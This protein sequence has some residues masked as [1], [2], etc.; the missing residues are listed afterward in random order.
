MAKL[1]DQ[2]Q[3][4]AGVQEFE[5]HLRQVRARDW[6]VDCQLAQ[7]QNDPPPP[8]RREGGRK[9]VARN[10]KGAAPAKGKAQPAGLSMETLQSRRLILAL[11]ALVLV[12]FAG[13]MSLALTDED[14][15]PAEAEAS[16]G[17]V[18]SDAPSTA[19]PT[20]QA[21]QTKTPPAVSA[22]AS[23]TSETYVA[24]IR[25]D[26]SLAPD[27]TPHTTVATPPAA[28]AAPSPDAISGIIKSGEQS[29]PAPSAP[30]EADAPSEIPRPRN[31]RRNGPPRAP[32]ISPASIRP[33]PMAT[34]PRP[35]PI[36]PTPAPRGGREARRQAHR[37]ARRLQAARGFGRRRQ[38]DRRR[39]AA[40]A[41]RR[42]RRWD[43][44]RGQAGRRLAHW[45]RQETCRSGVTPKNRS[46]LRHGG[47]KKIVVLATL[48]LPRPQPGRPT[49][50]R[51]SSIK[52]TRSFV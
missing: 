2:Q 49:A 5:E 46:F 32:P 28:V 37:Q 15:P 23:A 29:E 34:Q 47:G 4:S 17:A 38:K 44:R 51:S 10:A 50:P 27:T 14:A 11:A 31:R 22:P 39:A 7:P 20:S 6:T 35:P 21:T 43:I 1:F 8:P 36:P 48:E 30:A 9:A 52:E 24:T 16:V 33:P 41:R 12:T 19:P 42:R 25:P 3:L 40:H 18:E 45:S 26:G 13:A